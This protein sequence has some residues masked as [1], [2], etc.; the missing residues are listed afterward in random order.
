MFKNVDEYLQQLRKEL[1]GGDPA[2]IQDALS[3][4]EEHLRTALENV[5]ENTP[6]IS[7]AEALKP[8]IGD[9]G[10][11]SEIA[12][13]YREIESRM[14]PVIASS[15]QP[16]TQ[17][18][19]GRFFSILAS[20]HAWGAF[21]YMLFS[22][23][24]GSIYGIWALT[25]A[26]VSLVSLIL[27]I[28]IPITGLFLLSVRGI[29]LMEGRIVEALLGVRMPRKPIFV[30]KELRWMEKL[31][32]LFTESHTWKVLVYMILQFP[33]GIIYCVIV[34]FMFAGSLCAIV[35]PALR[36]VIGLP[37]W[38][39]DNGSDAI[40]AWWLPFIFI[41]G[42]LLLALTMH[43]AKFIGKTHGRFAKS[44]LVRK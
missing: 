37:F 36:L 6:S 8:I 40:S 28:G 24:T 21:L 16:K 35:G 30:S 17:S 33:L 25:G 18:F 15:R 29:G 11:P 32:A 13:A 20:P 31:K 10:S 4:A 19:F 14:S 34:V 9:Y 5:F 38:E 7:E 12:S 41:G 43:L 3:D 39:L 23:L 44:M 27:I 42:F 2:L 26:T 22:I 1:K